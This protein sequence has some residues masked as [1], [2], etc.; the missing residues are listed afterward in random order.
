[1]KT[2]LLVAGLTFALAAGAQTLQIGGAP[3]AIQCD[4]RGTIGVLRAE[5]GTPVPQ[6]YSIRA[7]GSALFLDGTNAASRWGN[8]TSTFALW[9]DAVLGRFA[10]VGHAVAGDS[11]R[12]VLGA[13]ESGVRVLQILTY[14]P[15]RVDYALQ[16]EIS[17]GSSRVFR[18]LRFVHGGDAAL[19][20]VDF[21]VGAWEAAS[22]RVVIRTNLLAA[23]FMALGSPAAT[24]YHEDHFQLVRDACKSGQLPNAAYADPH[25]AA[26]ALQWNRATLSPGQTWTIAAIETWAGGSEEPG[27]FTNATAQVV[28]PL[29]ESWQLNRQT[30]TYFGVL[31][32]Q[33][34]VG[35]A[36]LAPPV[37]LV[38]DHNADR[39]FMQ[40]TGI[41]PDGKQ[42][43]D[44][45]AQVA[46]AAGATLD[47]GE[48]VR[49]PAIEV[50]MRYRA[51]P[52]DEIFSLW[53]TAAGGTTPF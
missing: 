16:W 30:G 32:L 19:G 20:G 36:P 29:F 6:Y 9:D 33:L 3:L 8:G 45:T 43:L 49:V 44:L 15:G 46:A 13:G 40:P 47:A 50:Y 5:Q 31:R 37:W 2:F 11:I 4:E 28:H 52:T 24:A 1:M 23:D 48:T 41:T 42:Y 38:I 26:Y 17:N 7:K 51:N 25:D 35:S 34:A 39:R 10:P 21:A 18:D 12:T 22:N 53:A 14:L 27:T